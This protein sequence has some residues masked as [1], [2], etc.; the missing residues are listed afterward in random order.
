MD[1]TTLFIILLLAGLLLMGSEIFVPGGVLGV[2]GAGALVGAVAVGF[3]AFGP[4][5]GVLAALSILVFLGISIVLWMQLIP[6]TRLGKTLTLSA[7]TAGYK[8]A[9]TP[10]NELRGKEGEA[11][12]SL[13]PSGLIKLDGKRMDAIAEGNWIEQG[14]RVRVVQITGNH[15]TVREI[16]K[17]PDMETP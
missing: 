10:Y 7:D 8:S 9:K 13:G 17:T 1:P 4:Q 14:A 5:Q 6:R 15:I 11:L 16:P 3:V 12:S 2:I